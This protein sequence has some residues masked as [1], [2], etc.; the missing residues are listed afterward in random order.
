MDLSLIEYG[1]QITL[2][3]FEGEKREFTINDF[4]I[5]V[6]PELDKFN[7]YRKIYR[8]LARKAA[9]AFGASYRKIVVNFDA[10]L[11]ELPKMY[12]FYR[13]PLLEAAVNNLIAEGIYDVSLESFAQEHTNDFC[14]VGEDIRIMN[15]SCAFTIQNNRQ[16]TADA[17]G[18]V[19]GFIFSGPLGLAA[20]TVTNVSLSAAET[21]AIKNAKISNA[22]KMELF[23]RINTDVL[24]ERAYLDY[25][26]V[27]CSLCYKLYINEKNKWY[28]TEANENSVNNLLDNLMG[29]KIPSSAYAGVFQ[30][31]VDKSPYKNRFAEYLNNL[32]PNDP[33]LKEYLA[34][35]DI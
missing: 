16:R 22:Q 30:Q 4:P 7:T 20:A 35:I 34:Y 10:F 3:V 28:P 19:P 9:D 14:L 32:Y 1:K 11:I 17:L 5:V 33:G 2:P 24:I 29:G 25:W 21:A 31:I 8:N 6:S 23:K 27:F 12:V 18:I 13:A 26:R 15:E